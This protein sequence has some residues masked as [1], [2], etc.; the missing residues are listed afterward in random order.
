M[1]AVVEYEMVD[2]TE[3]PVDIAGV[4]GPFEETNDATDFG[5]DVCQGDW[6]VVPMTSP[7]GAG[8]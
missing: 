1:Y 3:T 5:N 2:D 7:A 4:F 6:I 8:Y